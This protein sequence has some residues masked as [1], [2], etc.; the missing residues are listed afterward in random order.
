MENLSLSVC[1][2]AC[3]CVS[4]RERETE[5]DRDGE[6]EEVEPFIDFRAVELARQPQSNAQKAL[7]V[8]GC[9]IT[10]MNV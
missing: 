4:G 1:V 8:I 2:C 10:G 5:R 9:I 6:I 7:C 3:V